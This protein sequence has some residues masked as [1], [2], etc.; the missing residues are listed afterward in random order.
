MLP[1][2]RAP[3][4]R[5]KFLLDVKEKLSNAGKNSH[6]KQRKNTKINKNK[7]LEKMN[8]HEIPIK[9]STEQFFLMSGEC[10]MVL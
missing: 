4:K 3:K 10:N 2:Y 5:V 1:L 6:E 9:Y 7:A 8:Y